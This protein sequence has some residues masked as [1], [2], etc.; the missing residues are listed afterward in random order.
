MTV[1]NW[2]LDP[3]YDKLP[4]HDQ[5]VVDLLLSN[6]AVIYS[7]PRKSG[8]THLIKFVMKHME[9]NESD[10]HGERKKNS[11]MH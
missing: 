3:E 8:K 11:H 10:S 2:R 5:K 9:Q 1:H 7:R 4:K 6:I